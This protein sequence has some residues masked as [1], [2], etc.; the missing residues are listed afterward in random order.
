MLTI[1]SMLIGFASSL[2]PEFMKRWQDRSDKVHELKILK[3]Q[4]ENADRVAAYRMDEIG[5]E[6]YSN[7]VQSAHREQAET[8]KGAS[9]WV[10]NFSASVRPCS[11]YLFMIAFIGFKMCIFLAAVNP[12]LPW[13]SPLTFSQAMLM[14][15]GE[16]E[17]AIFAGIMAYWF[18]DRTMAKSRCGKAG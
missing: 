11:T 13:H 15:W 3:I 14:V 5:V 10:I 6:A 12:L 16:E 4:M 18:G 2:A 17:T 1:L 8:L 7:I 9:K